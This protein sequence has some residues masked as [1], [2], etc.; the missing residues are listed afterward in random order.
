VLADSEE[1]EILR[2][3]LIGQL[4]SKFSSPFDLIEQF[5]GVYYSGLDFSFYENRF[6]YLKKFTATDLLNIGE[7]YFSSADRVKVRVG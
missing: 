7:R 5:K 6:N 3:Y 1:I 2:N 4:F